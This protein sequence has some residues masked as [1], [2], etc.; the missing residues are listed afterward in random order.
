ALQCASSRLYPEAAILLAQAAC[1]LRLQ[2]AGLNVHQFEVFP[3]LPHSF[4]G[5][6]ARRANEGPSEA[7]VLPLALPSRDAR[8]PSSGASPHLLPPKRAGEG[9][10]LN[11][12][13]QSGP[14][15][16]AISIH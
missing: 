3:L 14:C 16:T 8:R 5:E 1:S 6:G 9:G 13:S 12:Q 2:C 4:P 10:Q 15:S 11:Q 7:R